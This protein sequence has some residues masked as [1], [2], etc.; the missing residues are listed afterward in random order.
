M[1][2]VIE[3]LLI[4]DSHAAGEGCHG[5]YA[6]GDAKHLRGWQQRKSA[7]NHDGWRYI[8]KK[9]IC[10]PCAKV[11]ANAKEQPRDQ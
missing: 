2:I 10:P 7:K 9:D 8:G 3:T 1:A 11:N 4:C 6:D 5:T